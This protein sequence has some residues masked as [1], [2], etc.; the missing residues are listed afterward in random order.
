MGA[1]T[2]LLWAAILA[3]GIPRAHA[4]SA[5]RL[6]HRPALRRCGFLTMRSD[7][8]DTN[9]AA[10]DGLRR[11]RRQAA[12]HGRLGSI[13]SA[14]GKQGACLVA[15]PLC[16]HLQPSRLHAAFQDRMTIARY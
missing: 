4:W 3:T 13:D 11:R 5:S 8:S 1:T 15:A 12:L 14:D 16:E 6:S 2:V 7:G 9:N 10:T